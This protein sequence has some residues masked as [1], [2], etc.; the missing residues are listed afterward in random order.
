MYYQL[1]ARSLKSIIFNVLFGSSISKKT[2]VAF[3]WYESVLPKEQEL[4]P[5]Y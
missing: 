4:I 2:E 1:Q 5:E 3:F